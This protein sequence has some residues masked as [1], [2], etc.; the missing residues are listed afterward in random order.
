MTLS[1]AQTLQQ[2]IAAQKNGRIEEAEGF[3]RAVLQSQP[4]NPY[5]NHNLGILA[6]SVSNIEAAL[7]FF[8]TALEANPTIEEFWFSY[9][10]ALIADQQLEAAG[11]V[12]EQAKKRGVKGKTLS[13]RKK[14]LRRNVNARRSQPSQKKLDNL[15]SDYQAGRL[16]EAEKLAQS[17][18]QGF[19]NHPLPWKVLGAVMQQVGR[20]SEAAIANQKAVELSPHDAEAHNNLGNALLVLGKLDAAEVSYNE[21]LALD[22]ELV[23]AH[24]NLGVT[25]HNLGRLNEAEASYARAVAL[26]PEFVQALNN[27]GNTLKELGRL[28]EAES[29]LKQAIVL[30]PDH[31]EAH[32][33]LG[34]IFKELGR[35][36][37]AEAS[38][39]QAI[40]HKPDHA[41]AHANLG[42]TL[43][44]LGRLDEATASY[45]QAIKLKPD[46]AEAHRRLSILKRFS[47][48]D[49]QCAK[50]Q[51]L[52]NDANIS[53]EERCHIN[54]GLA[55]AFED[56]QDYAQAYVHLS[57]G[58]AIRKKLLNYDIRQDVELF[59]QL[60]ASYQ[61]I[62][63]T[64][65]TLPLPEPHHTPIFIV[66]MPRSGTT[67]LE[68]IISAHSLVTA[69]GELPYAAQFGS[70]IVKEPSATNE[71]TLIK[72]RNNYLSKLNNKSSETIFFTDKMPQNFC[73]IGLLTAAL[74]E[75]KI[76]HI[77][78]DPAAVCWSNFK[79]YFGPNALGY[80][81]ALDDVVS[82]YKLYEDLMEFWNSL[83]AD[84]IYT[85]DYEELVVDQDKQTRQLIDYLG[86]EWEEK[87]LSPHENHRDVAT[88][89]NLQ[90]RKRIYQG[91]SQQWKKYEPMLNGVFDKLL[92][93]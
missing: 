17:L 68:Q 74:P 8:K 83:L 36:R 65:L 18:T 59:S 57:E 53:D 62:A 75:A 64:R 45:S 5:A 34:V 26:K 51:A 72:F 52:Y 92:K 29:T 55:K 24:N 63:K 1:I 9:I 46:F 32:N 15:L 89:S 76:I 13:L 23:E 87:C 10:D 70:P 37:E 25:L 40:A 33:N 27:R 54:F 28:E 16:G 66:G 50:M 85:V 6:V 80:C 39:A 19:P 22:P 14:Q 11:K 88:A 71:Q 7:P 21:A 69:A 31:S 42:T 73:F 81:Y 58:N 91:S 67:L 35:L 30:M 56:L 44:E 79:Q 86:L 12:I 61:H 38:Y 84:S 93:G 47:S 41:F 77:R 90:V 82:Y 78:R 49:E 43:Q 3:Y 48:R 60:K 2:G 20:I 4:L